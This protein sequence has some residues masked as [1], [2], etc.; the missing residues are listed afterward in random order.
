MNLVKDYQIYIDPKNSTNAVQNGIVITMAVN[1]LFPFIEDS[2]SGFHPVQKNDQAKVNFES[3]IV[4]YDL[5]S[6]NPST[7]TIVPGVYEQGN[8][9]QGRKYERA[10]IS[11]AKVTAWTTGVSFPGQDDSNQAGLITMMAHNT[12]V[13]PFSIN[14]SNAELKLLSPRVTRR[15]EPINNSNQFTS[16]NKAKQTQ[17]SLGVSVAKLNHITDLNDDLENYGFSLGS[18]T[19]TGSTPTAGVPNERSYVS[20]NYCP[21]VKASMTGTN[22]Q[23]APCILR[24]RLN[25]RI[26]FVEQRSHAQTPGVNWNL[27]KPKASS[28]YGAMA[29]TMAVLYGSANRNR[30]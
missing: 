7:A 25:Q 1:S 13:S 29:A 26:T 6:V 4:P 11:G 8:Y 22:V 9:S 21:A 15:I 12:R 10:Y 2:P 18:A 27:P 28:N 17:L 5:G 14:S 19:D 16:N 24:L 23:A 3:P 20:I 30:R